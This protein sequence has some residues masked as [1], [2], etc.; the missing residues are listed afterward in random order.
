MEQGYGV[1]TSGGMIHFFSIKG[2][3]NVKACL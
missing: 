3:N 1:T 2:M